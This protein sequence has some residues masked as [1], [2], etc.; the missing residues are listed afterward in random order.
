LV[1]YAGFLL[2]RRP[3]EWKALLTL[4][5]VA[6]A[7]LVLGAFLLLVTSADHREVREQWA[8]FRVLARTES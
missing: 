6:V 4:P 8:H 5:R 2:S 3:R 7:A 1:L